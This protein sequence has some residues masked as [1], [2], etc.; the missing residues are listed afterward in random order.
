[1]SENNM[2][3]PLFSGAHDGFCLRENC[4]YYVNE[5]CTY[6]K[7][8]R[9]GNYQEDRGEAEKVLLKSLEGKDGTI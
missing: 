6:Q 3:C 2:K 7:D 5:R 4:K 9:K 1:M 8:M